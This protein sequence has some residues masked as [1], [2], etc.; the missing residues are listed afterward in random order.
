MLDVAINATGTVE[1]IFDILSANGKGL[2]DI[3]HVSDNYIIPSG[4]A[5]DATQLNYIQENA[6]II[7][8]GNDPTLYIGISYW[9][10]E[11]DFKIS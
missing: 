3:P 11:T 9:K 4:T 5:V 8:T 1:S 6:L 7:A 10:I 2:T